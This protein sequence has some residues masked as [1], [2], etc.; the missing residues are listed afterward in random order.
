MPASVVTRYGQIGLSGLAGVASMRREKRLDL[1]IR[2]HP[3]DPEV[4]D[5]RTGLE[6]ETRDV[7]GADVPLV[8][9]PVAP[10][11]DMAH[12]IEVAALNQ[13]LKHLGHDAA[14]ELDD[15]LV[16]ILTRKGQ[17]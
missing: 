4:E 9:L 7:M 1:I 16:S 3:L 6:P 14:K 5:D 8:S 13:K 2:L 17:E 11:R 15:K 12:V 10:G